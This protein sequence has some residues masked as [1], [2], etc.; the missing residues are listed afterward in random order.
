VE[1]D[2]LTLYSTFQSNEASVERTFPAL[3][4]A[5][6]AVGRVLTTLGLTT[7]SPGFNENHFNFRLGIG[8]ETSGLFEC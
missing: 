6:T 3:Q 7:P 5:A 2:F 1:D 4:I 8:P